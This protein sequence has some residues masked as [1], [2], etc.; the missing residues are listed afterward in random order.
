MHEPAVRRVL[1]MVTQHMGPDDL[2]VGAKLAFEPALS[3]RELAAAID[4]C[5]ARVRAAVPIARVIYLE[6]GMIADPAAEA[7]QDGA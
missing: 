1:H 6:P 3:V 5:E 7:D 2:F 4:A